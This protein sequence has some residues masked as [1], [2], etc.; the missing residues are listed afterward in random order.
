[1]WPAPSPQ[2]RE[3]KGELYLFPLQM[4]G[5]FLMLLEKVRLHIVGPRNLTSDE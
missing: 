5:L 3:K 4:I 1:M 2:C